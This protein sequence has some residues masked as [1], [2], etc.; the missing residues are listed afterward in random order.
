M[1]ITELKQEVERRTGVPAA[2]LEG[3]TPEAIFK[4]ARAL[5]AIKEEDTRTTAE[6]FTGWLDGT[7]EEYA[8]LSELEDSLRPYSQNVR[9]G[10]EVT[11]L[12]VPREPKDSFADWWNEQTAYDPRRAGKEFF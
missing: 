9:D 4:R 10:G 8:A 12:H 3:D 5:L 7:P 1:E 6:Q 11:N 2:L